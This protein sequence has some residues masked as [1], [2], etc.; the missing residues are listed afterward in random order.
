MG[1]VRDI[2]ADLPVGQARSALGD[3][4]SWR[5][6]D[7][8]ARVFAEHA[9]RRSQFAHWLSVPGTPPHF[10]VVRSHGSTGGFRPAAAAQPAARQSKGERFLTQIVA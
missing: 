9:R 8:T 1:P 4:D 3:C 2:F 10:F 6:G 7:G 5:G